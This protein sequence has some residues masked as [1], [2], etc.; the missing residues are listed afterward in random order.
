MINCDTD[1]N[2]GKALSNIKVFLGVLVFCIS[3]AIRDCGDHFVCCDPHS[4][5]ATPPLLRP[6]PD[7]GDPPFFAT[8]PPLPDPSEFRDPGSLVGQG[9]IVWFDFW[10]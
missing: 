8:P 4:T 9:G 3:I 10:G 1:A 7:R 5:V 6:P 2:F